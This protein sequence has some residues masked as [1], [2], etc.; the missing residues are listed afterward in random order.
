MA[1]EVIAMDAGTPNVTVTVNND[2]DVNKLAAA[3]VAG[4]AKPEVAA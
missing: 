2:I 1:R 4:G 3:K